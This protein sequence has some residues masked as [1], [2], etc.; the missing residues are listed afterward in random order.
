MYMCGCVYI[1]RLGGQL[2]EDQLTTI[3]FLSMVSNDQLPPGDSTGE[4]NHNNVRTPVR[5]LEQQQQPYS[6]TTQRQYSSVD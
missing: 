1:T 4:H 2:G 5:M 3:R 6:F